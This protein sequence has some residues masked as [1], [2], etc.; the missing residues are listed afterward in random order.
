MN[1]G[2]IASAG[3]SGHVLFI[4]SRRHASPPL[5]PKYSGVIVNFYD[6]SGSKLIFGPLLPDGLN[7]GL[8]VLGADGFAKGREIALAHLYL[9]RKRVMSGI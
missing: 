1:L 9:S 5:T 7:C 4:D 6:Y 2:F 8:N 3:R